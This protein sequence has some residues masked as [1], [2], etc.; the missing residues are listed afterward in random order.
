MKRIRY[1]LIFWILTA[2]MAA[3]YAAPELRILKRA[4][5]GLLGVLPDGKRVLIVAGTP[6]EMGEAQ[7]SLLAS[8][9][10]GVY[11]RV[12]LTTASYLYFKDD[13]FFDRISEV[14]TRAKPFT[15]ERF[16]SECEAMGHAAGIPAEAAFQIN[17]F[18]EM[19][20][21]SGIA[22]RGKASADG[23]VR[24]A[25]VLDYMR[26]LGLQDFAVLTVCLPEGGRAWC[27]VGYAGFVGTV[28]AMNEAGLAIGEMGGGG[29][30][31]WDGIPTG[32]LMRRIMEEC[33]TVAEAEKLMKE[34]PHTCEY[35]YV[36]SD[37]TGD[38]AAVEAKAGEK[39]KFFRPGQTHPLLPEAFEDVV[40]IS[41]GERLVHLHDQIKANY[42]KIDTA[43]LIEMI[44][45]PVAMNSNL[46]DAIF[47]PETL[48]LSWAN[49]SRKSPACDEPYSRINLAEL[50]K[51]YRQ[52]PAGN[53]E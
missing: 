39:P 13:W 4:E 46:H 9:I 47:E 35:Y 8:E 11:Q 22:L 33:G 10:R 51:W 23:K 29:F 40:Y 27:N 37:R 6:A 21:C 1:W 5:H 43:A 18:P 52:L 41:L 36:L 49:A 7:G 26:D 42:G 30:G 19:F 53:P 44:K 25:R 45:R 48:D 17:F 12:L 32:F 31:N 3:A 34:V 28:T 16:L 15:P 2:V 38:M 20:H 14:E 24:H 50:V